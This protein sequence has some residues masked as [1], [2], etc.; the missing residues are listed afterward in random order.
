MME[1]RDCPWEEMMF[2]ANEKKLL[3]KKIQA[4]FCQRL[5]M[6]KCIPVILDG[7][8]HCHGVPWQSN[9]NSG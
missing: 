1:V 4:H 7:S 6:F 8:E 2:L 9:V 5:V 3:E